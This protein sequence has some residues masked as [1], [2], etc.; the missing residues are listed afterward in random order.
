MRKT[1]TKLA[2]NI[3]KFKKGKVEFVKNREVEFYHRKHRSE[4]IF[5]FNI[6][7]SLIFLNDLLPVREEEEGTFYQKLRAQTLLC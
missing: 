4:R 2:D 3:T 7:P 1:K 6:T 5:S